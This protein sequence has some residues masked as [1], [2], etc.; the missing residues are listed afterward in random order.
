VLF[1]LGL[2][3]AVL[4]LAELRAQAVDREARAPVVIAGAVH[5]CQL[6]PSGQLLF[7]DFDNVPRFYHLSR[8]AWIDLPVTTIIT[9]PGGSF[10]LG[11]NLYF[12]F[13]TWREEYDARESWRV[14][15]DG[16][17]IDVA[18]RVITDT[19]TLPTDEQA[20]IVQLATARER[21]VLGDVAPYTAPNGQY[22][23][24][25]S[26]YSSATIYNSNGLSNDPQ[27]VVNTV[28]GSTYPCLPGW[29][30]DSQGYYFVDQQGTF[31]DN[32]GPVR[33]ILTHPPFPTWLWIWR[34]IGITLSV[35][36]VGAA[37]FLRPP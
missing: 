13:H 34:A 36:I 12:A 24:W 14:P 1:V 11:D 5:S 26:L 18:N 23:F 16:W 15:T 7:V 20:A 6:S 29:R 35:A 25:H 27:A 32:P 22:K 8:R 19:L 31:P 2:V 21:A 30:L 9:R 17:I 3:G 37:W 33:L 10:W 28:S 4:L